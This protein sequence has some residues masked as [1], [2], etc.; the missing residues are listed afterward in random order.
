M[1]LIICVCISIPWF[2]TAGVGVC[3]SPSPDMFGVRFSPVP[4][5][6]CILSTFVVAFVTSLSAGLVI[7]SVFSKSICV[8][9]SLTK[10]GRAKQSISGSRNGVF[11]EK[12]QMSKGNELYI[13]YLHCS[14]FCKLANGYN[15]I[16]A[17]WKICSS[18]QTCLPTYCILEGIFIYR[19]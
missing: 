15:W 19:A 18:N 5:V 7:A 4:D 8:A 17:C 13:I 12:T 11:L 3:F 16:K 6:F 1:H 10:I 9:I 14:V 2:I